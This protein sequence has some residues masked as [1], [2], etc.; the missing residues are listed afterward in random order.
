M[1]WAVA[2]R[3]L[4]WRLM[5]FNKPAPV[6]LSRAVEYDVR[7]LFGKKPRPRITEEPFGLEYL[8]TGFPFF[9]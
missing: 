4:P 3:E 2:R 7:C 1:Y 9:Q 6:A 8:F 5:I